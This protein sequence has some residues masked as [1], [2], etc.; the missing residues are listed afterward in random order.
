[1]LILSN[2]Q[3]SRLR[4]EKKLNLLGIN[5]LAIQTGFLKRQPKKIAPSS[6]LVSFLAMLIGKNNSL[7]S[8]ATTLGLLQN[9]RISKQAV[10]K[11]INTS[12]V[13]F[14][15][16]FLERSLSHYAQIKRTFS[17]GSALSVFIRVLIQD[18]TNIALAPKLIKHFPGS[19][20]GTG[21]STAMMKIQS[22]YNLLAEQFLQFD[23]S[24]FSKN[25]QSASCDIL[26][27]IQ[28]G[29]LVLRDLG[30]FVLDVLKRINS[31]NA[32]FLSRLK[33]GIFVFE[34]DGKTRFDLVRRLRKDSLLDAVVCLGKKE[35]FSVRLVTI[36]V[37]DEVAASRRRKARRNR[38][39]RMNPGKESLFLMGWDIFIT[40]ADCRMLSV[41]QIAKLYRLRWRIEILFKSWKSHFHI[42]NV[43]KA[44]VVRVL[45]YVY[46]TLIFIVLFQARLYL[47]FYNELQKN[48]KNQL[49]L[50]KLSKF[51][52]E[53]SWAI[54]LYFLEP[55]RLKEQIY[56]HCIYES[57][58][59]R[60]NHHQL[61]L[62][63]S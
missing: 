60:L 52:K 7:L 26:K 57:R 28:P 11:R 1:M 41:E 19:R 38:D 20:N 55:E 40:N 34:Q 56:Y 44:S 12:W 27:C 2:D 33:H 29:D 32:Y 35:K 59:D 21:R 58:K 17:D 24:H 36:P 23:I 14:L 16:S 37:T 46:A 54:M 39:R 8:I 53:Q 47:H 30:Y 6:L 15:K 4:L 51:V 49:S 13:V 5:E 22:I 45:A 9:K 62:A 63:L 31:L 18:S 48:N 3:E 25:D 42:M 10:D 61:M 50:F 43:P